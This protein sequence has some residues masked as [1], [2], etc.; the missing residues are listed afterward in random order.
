M[1]MALCKEQARSQAYVS[2]VA[3][4]YWGGHVVQNVRAYFIL[5]AITIKW[6]MYMPEKIER[7]SMSQSPRLG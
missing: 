4:L 2:G 5:N 3:R 7:S 6:T 1:R